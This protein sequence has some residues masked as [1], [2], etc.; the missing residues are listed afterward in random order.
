MNRLAPGDLLEAEHR[1]IGIGVQ[2]IGRERHPE[3]SFRPSGIQYQ[4]RS[5]ALVAPVLP[6]R[7]LQALRG[8][9]RMAAIHRNRPAADSRRGERL[10][11]TALQQPG[12]VEPARLLPTDDRRAELSRDIRHHHGDDRREVIR[13]HDL[14][15]M[16]GQALIGV[17]LTADGRGRIC[18]GE[19]IEK[20]G[21][22]R[23]AGDAADH[24]H[25][26]GEGAAIVLHLREKGRRR[27]RRIY[28]PARRRHYEHGIRLARLDIALP[29]GPTLE[30]S[31]ESSVQRCCRPRLRCGR[32]GSGRVGGPLPAKTGTS[33]KSARTTT[34]MPVS[35]TR[36][37]TD[38]H[39]NAGRTT[40]TRSMPPMSPRAVRARARPRPCGR[41]RRMGRACTRHQWPH[42][43]A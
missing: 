32:H 12:T 3:S 25:M 27:R 43:P 16:V 39:D 34:N 1:A 23:A 26:L 24:E 18:R 21:P 15:G 33:R 19:R 6:E 22:H 8:A 28:A 13:T 2:R 35:G 20:R 9:Q 4:P 37:R 30:P 10:G 42:P 38:S 41:Q 5:L 40:R 29:V 31:L 7:R 14:L 17:A 36:K 11:E